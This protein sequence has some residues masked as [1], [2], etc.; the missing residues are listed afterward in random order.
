M[1]NKA[2]TLTCR[3]SALLLALVIIISSLASC[4]FTVESKESIQ[5][6][7][8]Q[9]LSYDN[10]SYDYVALYLDD[11]GISNFD[12][13]KFTY[14]ENAV[15]NYYNYE[16]SPESI[17]DHAYTTAIYFLDNYYDTINLKDKTEVT[18]ALLFSYANTIGDPYCVYREPET[19]EN[20]NSDMSGKFGGIG[21]SI[22]YNQTKN[23]LLVTEI[24]IDSPAERAGIKVGDYIVGVDGKSI[25][26]LG[27]P[28]IVYAVR[29]EIG[30]EVEIT[31][32]RGDETLVVTA[33]R[34]EVVDKTVDYQITDGGY[35]YIRVS[36][37]KENTYEQF[38]EA[39]KYMEENGAPGI[40]FDLRANP[41]GYLTTV[42]DMLSYL[43]PNGETIVSYKYKNSSEIVIRSEDDVDPT[44]GELYDHVMTLPAVVICNEYTASAGEIFTAAIRDYKNDGLMSATVVGTTTFKKGI[45]QNTFL[46]NDSSSLTMT[47]AYYNPPGGVN[48]H[49][50]GVTPDVVVELPADATEDLQYNQAITELE[51]LINA[52]NH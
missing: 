1:K 23:T 28:D 40:I 41:G 4:A 33:T 12:I 48:Y 7:I 22:E 26:E 51:K 9:S 31:L 37:F 25:G 6:N 15:A 21:V 19:Y 46:Y 49:G 13:Y 32:L 10:R 52:N 44:T 2:K 3:V 27:Y 36:G 30:T 11:W 38:A 43:V 35:G 16:I 8:S 5:S 47:I 14:F 18:D 29:G 39:V 20:Y 24:N 34:E 50:V 42:C 45:M 17:L